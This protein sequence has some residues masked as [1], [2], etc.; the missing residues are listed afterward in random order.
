MDQLM[1]YK[2]FVIKSTFTL[3]IV[4]GI[5][6][7][8]YT[9]IVCKNSKAFFGLGIKA[10]VYMLEDISEEV[11]QHLLKLG[12]EKVQSLIDSNE[13]SQG[14]YY[15]Y[16]WTPDNSLNTLKKMDCRDSI[17]GTKP[18]LSLIDDECIDNE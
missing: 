6:R 14:E 7:G 3:D 5:E 15:C 4:N 1:E 17:W 8:G 18:L 16:Q 10:F 9:F 13:F 11:K 2:G 12:T